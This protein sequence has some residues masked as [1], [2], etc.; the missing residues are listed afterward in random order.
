MLSIGNAVSFHSPCRL[1]EF[2]YSTAYCPGVLKKN[3]ELSET[4]L[5]NNIS[6]TNLADVTLSGQNAM[7]AEPDTKSPTTP[8]HWIFWEPN[9]PSATKYR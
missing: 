6:G 9:V 5:I 4:S 7:C 8:F 1:L 3:T 2:G